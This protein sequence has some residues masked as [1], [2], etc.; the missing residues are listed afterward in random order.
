MATV[1]LAVHGG[2]GTISKRRMTP[3]LESEYRGGLENALRAGWDV[4]HRN[5]SSMDAVEA[6]VS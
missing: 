3:A 1:A 5:G 4:L 6:A 2:A